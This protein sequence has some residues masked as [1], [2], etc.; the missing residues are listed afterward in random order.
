MSKT[1]KISRRR[2]DVVRREKPY[3]IY[4]LRVHGYCRQISFESH[5]PRKAVPWQQANFS[6]VVGS[7][8]RIPLVGSRSVPVHGMF[9]GEKFACSLYSVFY[10]LSHKGNRSRKL[11]SSFRERCPTL[12]HMND[13]VSLRAHETPQVCEDQRIKDVQEQFQRYFKCRPL[14]QGERLITV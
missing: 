13:T 10:L 5:R 4:I 14:I 2:N 9:C 7:V 11:S 3:R 8:A 1:K 6:A 12:G